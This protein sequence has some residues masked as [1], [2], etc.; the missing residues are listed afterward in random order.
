MEPIPEWFGEQLN[1]PEG[2]GLLVSYVSPGS[3]AE[4]AG[5]KPH[6]I[7]KQIDD[8]ALTN[9]EQLST[10]VQSYAEGQDVTLTLLHKGQETK[11]T[12]KMHKRRVDDQAHKEIRRVEIHRDRLGDGADEDDLGAVPL[13]DL[14]K[15]LGPQVGE[16]AKKVGREA[17]DKVRREIMILRDKD[18]QISTSKL[19]LGQGRVLI[20]SVKG[21][22]E[23]KGDKEG[24]TTVIKDPQGK[25]IYH[26]PTKDAPQGSLDQMV[27]LIDD[28]G[29][30]VPAHSLKME[31]GN[32]VLSYER[33]DD[34]D[35][36]SSPPPK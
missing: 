13:N 27:I 29:V 24:S 18:G 36:K 35:R 19:D 17:A 28:G 12:A 5:V 11:L 23:I 20:R 16:L 1:L 8:Q 2:F 15:E 21:E 14:L 9:P 31:K 6:D 34:D 3:P 30:S 33:S 22:V 25:E 4:A 7:L 32:K 10:L 26:G